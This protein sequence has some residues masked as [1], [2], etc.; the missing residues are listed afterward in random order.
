MDVE[1]GDFSAE[2]L[3]EGQN[4]VFDAVENGGFDGVL[5][6]ETRV[7]DTKRRLK[8]RSKPGYR[9]VHKNIKSSKQYWLERNRRARVMDLLEQH[10]TYR[11]I[12]AKLGVSERTVKR[13]IAKIR[14]YYERRVKHFLNAADQE[15]HAKFEAELEGLSPKE[16][17]KLLKLRVKEN[18]YLL[19]NLLKQRD[20]LR[21][22][23]SITIDLD[24]L[25]SGFP[26]IEHKPQM[27]FKVEFPFKISLE[28]KKNGVI[29]QT[30]E[31]V[32]GGQG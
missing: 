11:Q 12:A 1:K 19:T 27:P 24:D 16:Q 13:D 14:P 9:R 18:Q 6:S 8:G 25:S 23:L 17:L 5:G 29:T 31:L 21:H 26:K 3:K 15:Q 4:G 2:K 7:F 20:Y 30:E 28:F 10:L 22:Q 32:L